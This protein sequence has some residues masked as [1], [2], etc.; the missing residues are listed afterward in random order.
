[1]INPDDSAERTEAG[2]RESLERAKYLYNLAKARVVELKGTAIDVGD[3]AG[4]QSPD[5]S[6][7]SRQAMQLQHE[8]NLQYQKALDEFARF[9]LRRHPFVKEK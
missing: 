2:L 1:M 5:R 3:A 8:A 6:T 7:A 4:H 9:V